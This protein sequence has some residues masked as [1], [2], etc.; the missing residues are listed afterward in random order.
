M[1]EH[2]TCPACG[3]Q[4]WDEP[5]IESGEDNRVACAV[6]KGTGTAKVEPQSSEPLVSVDKALVRLRDAAIMAGVREGQDRWDRQITVGLCGA[7]MLNAKDAYRRVLERVGE[8]EAE[9][10]GLT[11]EL[12]NWVKVQGGH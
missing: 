4:G 2:E 3:G 7:A 9:V 12:D 6:C 8:L 11:R 10:K 5:W 1:S